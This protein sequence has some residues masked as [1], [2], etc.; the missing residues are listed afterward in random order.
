MMCFMQFKKIL[1]SSALVLSGCYA[2]AA[3]VYTAH[4][5]KQSDSPHL[6]RCPAA[7]GLFDNSATAT[8]STFEGNGGLILL[9]WF[10]QIGILSVILPIVNLL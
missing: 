3:C 8:G 9:F 7:P 1:V 5:Y 2:Q 10:F 6:G 4:T